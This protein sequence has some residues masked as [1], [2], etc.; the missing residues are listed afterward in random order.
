MSLDLALFAQKVRGLRE[1]FEEELGELS[2]ATRI[3]EARL[4]DFEAG[5]VVPTGDEILILADHFKEDFRYFISN[6]QR[7][8]L[9]RTEKL[10][11]AYSKDLSTADRWAIQEFLFLCDNE[12][13]LLE[14]LGRK[15]KL[16]FTASVR[17][18][19]YIGH[20]L[21]A[22]RDLRARFG[23]DLRSIPKDVF[24]DLRSLG[25]H[26]FRRRLENPEL[27][28]L[29][30]DHPA[31]GP[32]LLINYSEDIYRQ[33][34]T[35]AHEAAHAIFD[36]GDEFIVSFK[37]SAEKLVEVRADTFAS[38]FL[39]PPDLLRT[40]DVAA[41]DE[42]R[43]LDLADQLKVSVRA[44][45]RAFVRDKLLSKEDTERFKHLRLPRGAKTDPELPES[46][47][48][49]QRARKSSLIQQGLSSTY[50]DLC[51]EAFQ[52]GLVTRARLGEMLLVVEADLDELLDLFVGVSP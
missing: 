5:T 14:E 31:A 51:V 18:N 7:T 19:Y 25:F 2:S 3:P 29:F 36:R 42:T 26:V 12:A 22:A 50:V 13:F 32:C 27:S 47:T 49:K 15:P 35:A 30:I 44:L 23:Y 46:L 24:S 10:F 9:E 6:E 39:V 52:R 16:T 11:R 33:R 1:M 43:L 21:E 34:F 28:G 45:L 4:R 41:L 17:G 38:A 40:L 37:W 8:V 48:A 20:G